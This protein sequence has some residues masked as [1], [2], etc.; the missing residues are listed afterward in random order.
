MQTIHDSKPLFVLGLRMGWFDPAHVYDIMPEII[1]TLTVFSLGF[2]VF[3]YFKVSCHELHVS[4]ATVPT[5]AITID[6]H[7]VCLGSLRS[8]GMYWLQGHFAP[9]S[10]DSGSTGS[11]IFDFYWGTAH[12]PCCQNQSST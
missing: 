5:R 9:S 10:T 6:C 1:S 11:V 12:V 7:L 8:P 4:Q 2:C 3:L